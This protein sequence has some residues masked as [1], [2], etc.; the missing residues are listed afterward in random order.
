V[1]G[2]VDTT[3]LYLRKAQLLAS[4]QAVASRTPN[5][6][7]QLSYYNQQLAV[8]EQQLKN[9]QREKERSQ[10]LVAAGAARASSWTI[11]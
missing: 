7:A 1:V 8:Q 9:L 3:Q 10:N 6:S 5:V 2:L 4:Q 11:W